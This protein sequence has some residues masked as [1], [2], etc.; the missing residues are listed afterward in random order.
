[1]L[2]IRK[3]LCDGQLTVANYFATRVLPNSTRAP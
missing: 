1:M 2:G 3:G